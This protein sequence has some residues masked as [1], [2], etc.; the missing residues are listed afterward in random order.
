MYLEMFD[1]VM[2]VVRNEA[3]ACASDGSSDDVERWFVVVC[4][5]SLLMC[6]DL[7]LRLVLMSYDSVFMLSEGVGY[8]VGWVDCMFE[9]VRGWCVNRF[10]VKAVSMI[11]VIVC[12]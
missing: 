1:E 10:G 4:V 8:G 3:G 6:C 2:V 7:V 9:N 11:V 12:G 5:W